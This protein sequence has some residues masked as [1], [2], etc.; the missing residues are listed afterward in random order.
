MSQSENSDDEYKPLSSY[1][2][3]ERQR[4]RRRR[5]KSASSDFDSDDTAPKRRV[6]RKKPNR[7]WDESSSEEI[8]ET[9]ERGA[10]DSS[11]KRVRTRR[12]VRI[13][14]HEQPSPVQGCTNLFI[15]LDFIRLNLYRISGPVH[16]GSE[17]GNGPGF[18][19]RKR[20]GRRRR[21]RCRD[22]LSLRIV[23]DGSRR[24]GGGVL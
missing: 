16:K 9:D 15:Q 14:D 7:E 24:G 1:E 19:E 8:E 13:Y 20:N 6:R 5:G 11:W 23:M 22:A 21:G 4:R 12:E 2:E 18:G 17:R 10:E 3:C